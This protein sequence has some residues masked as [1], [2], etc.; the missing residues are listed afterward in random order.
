MAI[1]IKFKN[2]ILWLRFGTIWYEAKTTFLL[3][4]VL[5]AEKQELEA[6]HD[7]F[8]FKGNFGSHL[9]INPCLRHF[10]DWSLQEC[11]P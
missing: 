1:F 10:K 3:L 6:L 4:F 7:F 2:L 8:F 11:T 9:Q 5:T